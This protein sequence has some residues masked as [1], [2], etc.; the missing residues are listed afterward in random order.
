MTVK[1]ILFSGAMVRALLDGRKTQTRR[2]LKNIETLPQGRFHVF[3]A[4]GGTVG[5]PECDVPAEALN[6]VP[7]AAGD[8]LYVRENFGRA[9]GGE[10]ICYQATWEKDGWEVSSGA[11][12][13]PSIHMPRAAS[14]LTL[15]VQKVR[16]QRLHDINDTDA[17][18]EGIKPQHKQSAHDGGCVLGWGYDGL[19]GY[20]ERTPAMAFRHLWDGLNAKR[21]F[22]W[23]ANSWVMALTFTVHKTN[24]DAFLEVHA[25]GH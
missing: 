24:I 16:V 7:Y 20:G 13:S 3:N 12:W 5:V 4:H 2:V 8:Y 18:A 25:S 10:P 23:D 14:R 17:V 19:D 6:Y 1:P 15:E 22:G 21:G 9:G 11:K